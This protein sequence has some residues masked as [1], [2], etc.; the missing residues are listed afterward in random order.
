M[1]A[2]LVQG[3]STVVTLNMTAQTLLYHTEVTICLKLY[4]K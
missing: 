2:T 3:F 4:L 1:A